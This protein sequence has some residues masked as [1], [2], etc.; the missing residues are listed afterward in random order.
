MSA[1]SALRLFVC[2]PILDV[3][4]YPE[5]NQS[6]NNQF[7]ASATGTISAIDG[8]KARAMSPMVCWILFGAN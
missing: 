6:N 4:V 2:E 5:G 7:L 1:M 3:Q 8:L